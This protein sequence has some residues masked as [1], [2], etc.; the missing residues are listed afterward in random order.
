MHTMLKRGIGLLI[1]SAI[2]AG[3]L[4]ASGV[5]A[6][7]PQLSQD[8]PAPAVV[9]SPDATRKFINYQGQLFNPATGGG[10]IN[11]GT[12][13]FVFSLY[14]DE[15]GSNRLWSEQ[16]TL[17]TNRDGTFNALLGSVNELT[18]SI[19]TGEEIFLGVAINGQEARPL[20]IISYVPYAWW[21]RNADKLSGYGAGDFTKA[22]ATGFIDG[23][24][25]K[26]SGNSGWGSSRQLVAGASV[27]V[28][29]ISGVDFNHRNFST[30]V[31]PSCDA[32]VFVGTGSS[33]GDLVID[34]W[35][36]FGNRTQCQLSFAIFAP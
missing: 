12:Y 34:I 1:G 2:V 33:Q 32:P 10:T 15:N 27:C 13:T 26:V 35:D 4:A 22:L 6:Q 18:D 20:Q 25:N 23:G 9:A 11:N 28:V 7:E 5:Q 14:R 31:T 16:Q 24:C 30:Q 8:G 3:V 17:T 36:R 19:F 29:D 21:A